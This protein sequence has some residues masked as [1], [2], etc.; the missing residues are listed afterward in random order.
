MV[1]YPGAENI[2][3]MRTHQELVRFPDSEDDTFI[4]ISETLADKLSGLLKTQALE[5]GMGISSQH[6]VNQGPLLLLPATATDA[7]RFTSLEDQN[8]FERMHNE[9]Y[10]SG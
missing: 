7:G 3:L 8:S 1:E 2:A 5:E 6:S 9:V 10:K 4:F